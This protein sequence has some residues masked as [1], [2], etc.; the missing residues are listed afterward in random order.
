M[1]MSSGFLVSVMTIA[2]ETNSF[3]GSSKVANKRFSS[4]ALFK[5]RREIIFGEQVKEFYP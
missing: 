3:N 1:Y 2:I 5:E 4:A